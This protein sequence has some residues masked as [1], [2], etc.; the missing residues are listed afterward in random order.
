MPWQDIVLSIANGALILPLIPTVMNRDAQVPRT[1][2]IPT[3]A[4]IFV[5]G[6]V[7][8]SLGLWYA[9]VTAVIQSFLWAFIAVRR[10]VE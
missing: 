6:M 2:S 8:A 4:C 7:Y 3:G 5:I 1:T 10:P 9:V